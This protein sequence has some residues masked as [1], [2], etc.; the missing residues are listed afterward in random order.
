MDNINFNPVI[1]SILFIS[2][3]SVPF[4]KIKKITN[5][6]IEKIKNISKQLN[7]SYIENHNCF[8]IIEVANGLQLSTA[9]EYSLWIRK[10][11]GTRKIKHFSPSV[12]EVLSILAYKQPITKSK[13]EK[14][15]GVSSDSQISNLIEKKMVEILGRAEELGR[16][17]MYGTTKE[18]L[19]Y[20]GLNQL[21]DLPDSKELDALLKEQKPQEANKV[22][23]ILKEIDGN[24]EDELSEELK[25]K[26]Q[27]ELQQ[28]LEEKKS[29]IENDKLLDDEFNKILEKDKE[30][31]KTT[32]ETLEKLNNPEEFKELIKQKKEVEDK[33]TF[34]NDLNSAESIKQENDI[35]KEND[36]NSAESEK[37]ENDIN[38]EN[39]NNN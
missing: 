1:E 39:I 6:E 26:K 3:N 8:R 7:K 32:N 16:P 22:K 24:D 31:R 33:T 29:E 36:F 15:R 21:S 27:K 34:E 10:F 30:I 14:V 20:F 4:E 23:K 2:G 13:I 28:K 19:E 38:K 37:Q 25:Q 35:N 9:S 11:F 5:L 17:L 18:F 12:L